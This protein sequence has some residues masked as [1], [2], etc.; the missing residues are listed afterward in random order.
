[1]KIAVACGGTGGH[2]FPG[3]ATADILR[4]RGHDIRLW[5]AGKDVEAPAVKDWAGPVVTVQAEGLPSG[6]SLRMLRAAWKLLRAALSCRKIMRQ[7]RPDV[8]LAMGSYASAGPVFAAL[9]LNVP[10]VLHEANV[11][12]GRAIALFSRWATA[13][14]GSFEETR[15]YL[16]RKDLVVT[17]MPIRK[18]LEKAAKTAAPH[19]SGRDLFTVLVMGGSRG[20]HRLN[21]LA[22]AAI[23]QIHKAGHRIRVIHLTGTVDEAAIRKNYQDAGVAAT[24]SAF[25]QDMA[26]IYTSTDLAICRSG[27]ST[28][29]EL[30]DFAVPALQI[31]YPG[32]TNDHQMVN[33]RAMEKSGAVDVVPEHDLS[34]SWLVDYIVGCMQT[35]GRLARMSAATRSRAMQSA[36]ESLATLVVQ[37][38]SGEYGLSV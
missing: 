7:N 17:G 28:C 16:R 21:D 19:E 35:P 9:S 32:A 1:L 37:V 15:F 23:A 8:L 31:P 13:V 30:S 24:V 12:P 11:L 14:A 33:A 6:F 5:L 2:I 34:L 4:E 27:A 3:L 18:D 36:A 38:G 22:S 29:A 10:V 20:A 26:P 25:E